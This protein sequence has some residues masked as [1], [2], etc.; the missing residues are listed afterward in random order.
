M[1]KEIKEIVDWQGM[2]GTQKKEKLYEI[3]EEMSQQINEKHGS[4]IKC[5]TR[6]A[7]SGTD[8]RGKILVISELVTDYG[9]T[10]EDD[11]FSPIATVELAE[12]EWFAERVKSEFNQYIDEQGRVRHPTFPLTINQTPE[13]LVSYL[14]HVLETG[15]T[16]PHIRE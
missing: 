14:E 5:R 8:E 11:F 9:F 16:R 1:T 10:E 15:E 13:E 4:R 7:T 2:S 12:V 3:G 6:E